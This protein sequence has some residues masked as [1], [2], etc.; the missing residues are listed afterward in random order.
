MDM[1]SYRAT[2]DVPPLVE[3]ASALAERMGFT[4]SCWPEVGRLLAVLA[5]GVRGGIIGETGTGC[6]VGTA[7]MAGALSSDTRLLTVELDAERAGAVRQL[8]GSAPN[9]RVLEGDWHELL[10]YGPFDMLFVDG[11]SGK[12]QEQE[13]VLGALRLGGLVV[14]DDLWPEG[15]EPPELR[16]EPD[17]VREFWLNHPRLVATEILTG[18]RMAVILA[19][20]IA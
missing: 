11:G 6:G 8:L 3:R 9:V 5:S 20:R 1:R 13:V 15:I 12:R 19:T 4:Q 7:W 10:P 14:L 18:P 2:T 17:P 16:G